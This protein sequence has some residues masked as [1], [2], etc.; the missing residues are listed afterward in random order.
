M[1]SRL[2]QKVKEKTGRA[3]ATAYP[4]DVA[5]LVAYFKDTASRV[6][7]LNSS[8][9]EITDMIKNQK[10]EKGLDVIQEL[11]QSGN[12]ALK[13]EAL[14]ANFQKRLQAETEATAKINN[15]ID[16]FKTY[17]SAECK[18]QGH[19]LSE[20]NKR[21]L[22]MDVALGAYN[23]NDTEQN[24][25]KSEQAQRDYEASCAKSLDG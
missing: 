12:S 5:A 22:D 7:T 15:E 18:A 2:K 21:R 4:D 19:V 1:F 17:L 9:S 14:V 20:L 13:L 11:S 8:V 10:R 23:D 6:K 25:L 3:Q 16:K 24:K